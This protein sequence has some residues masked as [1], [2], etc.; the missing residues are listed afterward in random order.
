MATFDYDDSMEGPSTLH[1]DPQTIGYDDPQSEPLDIPDDAL[2]DDDEAIHSATVIS[3]T[4]KARE[5][6]IAHDPKREPGKT[7]A[8]LSKVRQITK[9]DRVRDVSPD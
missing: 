8:P 1:D 2:A 9:A 5:K 3:D 7:H 4:K 6:K